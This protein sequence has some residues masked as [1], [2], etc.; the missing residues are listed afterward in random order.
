[1]PRATFIG[2]DGDIHQLPIP[3]VGQSPGITPDGN[4]TTP[5]GS[6]LL[7]KPASTLRRATSEPT[8]SRDPLVLDLADTGIQ[9]TAL[10][11]S[12]AFFDFFR[13]GFCDA[14]GLTTSTEGLLVL[15]NG[16]SARARPTPCWAPKA[17]TDFPIS[18]RSMPMV[19][20]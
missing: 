5:P 13:D 18:P 4:L 9:L 8:Q 12:P 1:M 16:Q 3:G 2:P 10:A 19:T 14:D 7:R 17:A 6:H 20:A 15:D 11:G